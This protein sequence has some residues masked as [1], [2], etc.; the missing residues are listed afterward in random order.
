[1]K[2]TYKNNSTKSMLITMIYSVG[3]VHSSSNNQ[4]YMYEGSK[5]FETFPTK[6]FDPVAQNI[7][8]QDLMPKYGWQPILGHNV[9]W[10]PLLMPQDGV[11]PIFG[12]K[13]LCHNNLCH[14]V[15]IPSWKCL[16][17]LG[18]FIHVQL[19]IGT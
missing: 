12:H 14:R 8:A 1:M 2:S 4:L 11:P 10:Q 16:K 17:I 18:T 15:K 5:N 6:N 19:I 13:V 7:M 9:G 3:K